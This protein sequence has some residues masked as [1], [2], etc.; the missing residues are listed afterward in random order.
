[1]LL[2]CFFYL[3]IGV[4]RI[5]G[6]ADFA[7]GL[8]NLRKSLRRVFRMEQ[9]PGRVDVNDG[10]RFGPVRFRS[11]HSAN[12]EEVIVERK[13][14]AAINSEEKYTLAMQLQS[15]KNAFICFSERGHTHTHSCPTR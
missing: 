5:P 14:R 7:H 10:F 3:D 12:G 1:M 11:V 2:L 9:Q 15:L 4:Q 13:Q 8:R 6:V